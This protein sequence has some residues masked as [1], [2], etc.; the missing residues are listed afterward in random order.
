M[1]QTSFARL[2]IQRTNSVFHLKKQIAF[3]WKETPMF[4]DFLQIHEP[5]SLSLLLALFSEV[6]LHQTIFP[7]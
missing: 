2:I 7:Q 1:K 5:K 3:K 6:K 4:F